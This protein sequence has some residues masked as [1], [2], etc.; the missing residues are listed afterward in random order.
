MSV[1]RR[2]GKN[3]LEDIEIVNS[4]MPSPVL[5]VVT[6]KKLPVQSKSVNVQR[7]TLRV[8]TP[9]EIRSHDLLN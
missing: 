3:E 1:F 9:S 6:R 5:G 2:I 8:V 4:A 7:M